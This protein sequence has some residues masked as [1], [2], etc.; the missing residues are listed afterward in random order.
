MTGHK[1]GGKRE[2]A[3]RALLVCIRHPFRKRLLRIY[4]E[5]GETLSPKELTALTKQPYLSNVSYHVRVLAEHGAL[6]LVETRPARGSVE[7]FYRAGSLVD[8]VPWGRAA[9]GLGDRA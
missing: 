5:K 7:H 4:V 2:V 3:E 1:G 6:E 9:L 8:D